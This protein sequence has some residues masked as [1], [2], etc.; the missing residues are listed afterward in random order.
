MST[1][2]GD[3]VLQ[4]RYGRLR[5]LKPV[6]YQEINGKRRYITAKYTVVG[7]KQAGFSIA[8]YDRSHKLIIDPVLVYSTFLGGTGDEFGNAVALD[9]RRGGLRLGSTT[10]TDFPSCRRPCRSG[11]VSRQYRCL[12]C[13]STRLAETRLNFPLILAAP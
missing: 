12:S 3:L 5:Q 2:N 1:E 8:A 6:V 4:T 9:Y 11:N 7:N 13:E 10:S